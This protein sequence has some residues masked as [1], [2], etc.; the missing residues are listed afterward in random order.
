MNVQL[1][2]LKRNMKEYIFNLNGRNIKVLHPNLD[3]R[4][5]EPAEIWGTDPIHPLE[6]AVSGWRAVDGQQ[7]QRQ[8]QQLERP[9]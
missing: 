3:L 6:Q 9:P 8:H 1:E 7:H 5:L 2:E 4:G